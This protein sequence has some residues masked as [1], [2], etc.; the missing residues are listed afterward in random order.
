MHDPRAAIEFTDKSGNT[1]THAHAHAHTQ[2]H[3][4]THKHTHTNTPRAATE[5]TD[6]TAQLI[7]DSIFLFYFFFHL[8]PRQG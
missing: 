4:H 8:A 3:T 7:R 2:T 1:R 6:K 5:L